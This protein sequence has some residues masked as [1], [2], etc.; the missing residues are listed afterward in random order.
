[1][2]M[3]DYFLIG[4]NAV[5]DNFTRTCS[6]C[7]PVSSDG[8]ALIDTI[9]CPGDDVVQLIGHATRARHIGNTSEGEEGDSTMFHS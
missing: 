6:S 5:L 4:Q 7:V 9:G 1:M 8:H 2:I 3:G